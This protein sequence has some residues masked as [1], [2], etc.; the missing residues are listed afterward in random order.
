LKTT[1][2]N[3]E[4]NTAI[5]S[6]ELDSKLNYYNLNEMPALTRRMPVGRPGMR[7]S[8]AAVNGG[9]ACPPDKCAEGK[10]VTAG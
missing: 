2:I 5:I 9:S 1:Q 6:G 4:T 8:A 3:I 7:V 10:G